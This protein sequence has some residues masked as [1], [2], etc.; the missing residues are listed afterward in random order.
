MTRL[1]ASCV[2]GS[3]A[4]SL[5]CEPCFAWGDDGH[6]IVATIAT[7]QLSEPAQRALRELLGDETVADACCWADEVRSNRQYD[8]IKPLHYINVPRG[9]T[10]VDMQRDGAKGEQV[11]TSIAKYRDILKDTSR[12]KAERAEALKLLLHFVGDVHQPMHVSFKE[13]LGGNKLTVTS[14]GKKSNMHK[15]WDTDLIQRR[16]R[17]TKG[18]WATMSADLRQA[19]TDDQRKAW[20]A[21]TNPV[22]WANESL[23]ITLQLYAKAP[24]NAGVNDDYYKQWNATLNARLQAA[25]VRLGAMLNDTLKAPA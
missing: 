15:V 9:A 5:A 21:S 4:A 10:S 22:D 2:A 17:D 3:L 20:A 1:I 7:S 6:K 8:W 25:G 12:S 24:G 11:V 23:A 14:F 19:I 18:G 13:D 16:L